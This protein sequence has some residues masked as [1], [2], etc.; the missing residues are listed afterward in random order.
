MFLKAVMDAGSRLAHEQEQGIGALQSMGRFYQIS[1]KAT[2]GSTDATGGWVAP[3]ARVDEVIKPGLFENPYW[4]L[5]TI[6]T[7]VNSPVWIFPGG[8]QPPLGHRRR[9]W[10]DQ[11]QHRRGVQRVH[12][13]HVHAR[14]D[15]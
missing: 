15:L 7:G 13:D 5:M 9:P 8:A 14:A 1:G 3:N 4:Q 6:V 12:G 2:L 10:P 11:D